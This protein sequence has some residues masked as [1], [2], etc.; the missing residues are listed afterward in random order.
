MSLEARPEVRSAPSLGIRL[1]NS[2]PF[3]E[4]ATIHY[5]AEQAVHCGFDTLWVHDHIPWPKE[6][7]SHFA[8][9]SIEVCQDQPSHFFE[10]VSTCA[11][12]A[13]K[14]PD[15]MVGIA[16]LVLPLRDPRE[17]VAKR[18]GRESVAG[19]YPSRATKFEVDFGLWPLSSDEDLDPM[20][21]S[22]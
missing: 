6:Q 5:V 7:L 13:G 14:F 21:H 10:S 12:L 16:G 19:L 22:W 4:A 8:M 2:G 17:G 15:V 11:L 18:I 1:P 9:G 20:P 3:A